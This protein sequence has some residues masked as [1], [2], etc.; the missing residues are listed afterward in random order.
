MKLCDFSGQLSLIFA[1]IRIMPPCYIN[2]FMTQNIRYKIDIACL[3]IE[4]SAK[5]TAQ[6]MGGDMFDRR[7]NMG[8]LFD[9]HLNR[10]LGDTPVLK[11]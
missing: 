10:T 7:C 1:H 5:G 3:L 6:L 9:Q 8:I 11:R 4:G 2:V